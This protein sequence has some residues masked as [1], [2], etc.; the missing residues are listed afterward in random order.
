[1]KSLGS[2]WLT[3][4]SRPLPLLPK[5][6]PAGFREAGAFS[7]TGKMNPVVQPCHTRP[8]VTTTGA[9]RTEYLVGTPFTAPK[10]PM[11]G[12]IDVRYS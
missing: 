1:M 11:P 12:K 5:R 4:E 3:A 2:I 6:L 7:T 8:A 10:S 9:G